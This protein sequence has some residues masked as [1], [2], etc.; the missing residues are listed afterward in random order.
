VEKFATGFLIGFSPLILPASRQKGSHVTQLTTSAVITIKP[1]AFA[2]ALETKSATF[3]NLSLCSKLFITLPGLI[4]HSFAILSLA[5]SDFPEIDLTNNNIPN[6]T[7]VRA[8]L[9]LP[10]LPH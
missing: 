3:S 2:G 10:R 4:V 7:A 8:N 1:S 6:R 9:N 5:N